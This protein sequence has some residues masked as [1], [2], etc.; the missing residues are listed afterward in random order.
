VCGRAADW[1]PN[2]AHACR[3]SPR[4]ALPAQERLA[5]GVDRRSPLGASPA[6]ARPAQAVDREDRHPCQA[7][8]VEGPAPR[9]VGVSPPRVRRA[10]PTARHRHRG[11]AGLAPVQSCLMKRA[12]RRYTP[13]WGRDVAWSVPFESS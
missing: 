6:Q 2:D 5:S 1:Q 13:V 8:G 7:L 9:R 4:W 3:R 11:G 10:A 12:R